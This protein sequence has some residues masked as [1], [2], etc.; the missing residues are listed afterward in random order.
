MV[1]TFSGITVTSGLFRIASYID[2]QGMIYFAV[3]AA[4]VVLTIFIF[5]NIKDVETK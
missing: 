5:L 3:S 1:S 2:D 4:I